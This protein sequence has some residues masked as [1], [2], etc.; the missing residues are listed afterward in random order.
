MKLINVGFMR[1]SY[2]K[3]QVHPYK[4]ILDDLISRH[5]NTIP[6]R[7]LKEIRAKADKILLMLYNDEISIKEATKV[8]M[9]LVNPPK[10]NIRRR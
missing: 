1:E 4:Q 10:P 2:I 6:F 8:I 3:R 7:K 5:R 9:D